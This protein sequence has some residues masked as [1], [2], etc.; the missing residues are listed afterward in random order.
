MNLAEPITSVDSQVLRTIDSFSPAA[1]YVQVTSSMGR[2]SSVVERYTVSHA[3]GYFL[4]DEVVVVVVGFCVVVV[5]GFGGVVVVGATIEVVAEEAAVTCVVVTVVEDV[6]VEEDDVAVETKVDAAVVTSVVVAT[7]EDSA[8]DDGG[9]SA[10]VARVDWVVR[11][12]VETGAGVTATG[13]ED[14][15]SC[16]QKRHTAEHNTKKAAVADSHR[17]GRCFGAGTT[18]FVFSG[19]IQWG[20]KRASGRRLAPQCGQ[21]FI[22]VYPNV[23]KLFSNKISLISIT[24]SPLQMP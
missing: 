20:Q 8:A 7:E 15:L 13:A 5:V 23:S 24:D 3:V 4:A 11:A 17:I 18:R 21:V 16:G 14:R 9:V 2:S 12:V 22:R 10:K 6:A 1:L 19:V